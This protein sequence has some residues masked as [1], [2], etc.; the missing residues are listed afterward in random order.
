MIYVSSAPRQG[1]SLA[2]IMIALV[3]MGIVGGLIVPKV[4]SYVSKARV[5]T[6]KQSLRGLKSTI[7]MFN[8]QVGDYPDSLKDLYKKPINEELAKNWAGPYVEEKRLVDSWGTKIQYNKTSGQAHPYE[9]FSYGPKKK[10]AA[11]TER[12]DVWSL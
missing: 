6:T 10:A 7:E 3:I 4:F 9:L 5:D 2:E 8:A 11:K 1:F 12:I